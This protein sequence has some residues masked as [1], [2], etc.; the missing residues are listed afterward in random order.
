MMKTFILQLYQF[1]SVMVGAFIGMAGAMAPSV[2]IWGPSILDTALGS[3]PVRSHPAF[4]LGGLLLAPCMI[5]GIAAGFFFLFLP[6]AMR[7]PSE[8]DSARCLTTSSQV[9]FVRRYAKNLIEYLERAEIQIAKRDHRR[10][11]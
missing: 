4:L 10:M 9:D 6:I 11:Q 2:L 8:L 5:L 3:H 1:L 7:F